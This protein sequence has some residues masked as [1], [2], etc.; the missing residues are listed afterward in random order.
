M[1]NNLYHDPL[2]GKTAVDRRSGEDRRNRISIFPFSYLGPLRRKRGG[3]RGDDIGYVDIYDPQT[4]FMAISVVLL[5]LM[6]A[7][8]TQQHL[9]LGSAKEANPLMEAVINYGGMPAF[10]GFKGLMT[11]AAVAVIMLHKEWPLGRY[12]ARFCLWAY[13]LLSLYHLYLVA[14]TYKILL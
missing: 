1:K 11:V 9:I 2:T 8:M 3:R 10:Y 5:S 7:I 4:W 6:D 13:I 14:S 12:A